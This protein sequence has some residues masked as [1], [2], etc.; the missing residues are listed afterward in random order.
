MPRLC[1]IGPLHLSWPGTP[2][3]AI[4]TWPMVWLPA[5]LAPLA[6]FLHGVS[7]QRRGGR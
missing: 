3:T 4:A 5:F 1:D 2:F 7:L 6:V